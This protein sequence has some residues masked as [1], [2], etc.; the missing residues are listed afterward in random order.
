LVVFVLSHSPNKVCGTMADKDNVGRDDQ[1]EAHDA[2]E[3]ADV[4]RLRGFSMRERGR[5]I[6]D[7][8]EAAALIYRSRL[9][10]GLADIQR[11]PWPASTWEF[12]RKA[13]ARAQR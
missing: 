9:A 12:F 11:D 8:C 13:A 10:S 7:A 5:L 6:E 4:A 3:A 2:A 1:A